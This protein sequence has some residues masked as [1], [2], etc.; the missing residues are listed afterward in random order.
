MAN[1]YTP[2]VLEVLSGHMPVLRNKFAL[3]ARIYNHGSVK[4][5]ARWTRDVV[6]SAETKTEGT[7][8]VGLTDSTSQKVTLTPATHKV[9]RFYQEDGEMSVTSVRTM[10]EQRIPTKLVALVN[11]IE[12]AVA[13]KQSE[14]LTYRIGALGGGISRLLL[15]QAIEKL[16][17]QNAIA[18]TLVVHP[19]VKR[20]MKMDDEIQK[21]FQYWQGGQAQIGSFVPNALEFE[22]VGRSNQI[23]QP[24]AGQYVC[25]AFQREWCGIAFGDLSGVEAGAGR[26]VK[27]YYDPETKIT[28][29]IVQ[30]ATADGLGQEFLIDVQYDVEVQEEQLCVAIQC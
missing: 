26:F 9:A 17:L 11:D 14:V 13:E 23:Y 5:S 18:Q 7:Q 27:A 24:L 29:R 12:S 25:L 16:E 3:A 20:A 4:G 22:A 30:H 8:L 2:Y 21:L 15:T 1:D 28:F 19:S 6:G 10:A